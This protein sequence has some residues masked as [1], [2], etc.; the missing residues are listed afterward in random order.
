MP[1][2]QENILPN[3]YTRIPMFLACLGS[4]NTEEHEKHSAG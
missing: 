1:L 4:G 3:V 2:E